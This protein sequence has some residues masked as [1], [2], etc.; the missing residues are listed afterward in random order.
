MV[1]KKKSLTGMNAHLNERKKHIKNVY[2]REQK[3][4]I[5]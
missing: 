5:F 2:L 4:C 3:N 1:D